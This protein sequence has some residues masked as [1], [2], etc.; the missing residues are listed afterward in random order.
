MMRQLVLI[1]LTLVLLFNKF[2]LAESS[3]TGT[4]LIESKFSLIDHHGKAVTERSYFGKYTLI[5][6]GFTHCPKICP[7]GLQTM[8]AVVNKLGKTGE[9]LVPL[10]ITIDP[11]RDDVGRMKEFT[12]FFHEKLVGL[13]GSKDEVAKAAKSFRAYYGKVE[14][15]NEYSFDHSS[16]IYLMDKRGKYLSHFSS[17][18]GSD[19]IANKIKLIIEGR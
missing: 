16:I 2:C 13:T 4:E 9:A 19:S 11:A 12:G 8:A 17:Q 15:V 7:V 10:F 18:N 3:S 6:F 5:F 1:I 14:G